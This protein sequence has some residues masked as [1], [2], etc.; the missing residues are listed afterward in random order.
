MTRQQ[1]WSSK[2]YFWT[3]TA[4]ASNANLGYSSLS[5]V[6]LLKYHLCS[7]P[8]WYLLLSNAA[9]QV[10][11]LSSP[12]FSTCWLLWFCRESVC[13]SNYDSKMN[14]CH[15]SKETTKKYPQENWTMTWPQP[16]Y[17]LYNPYQAIGGNVTLY[18]LQISRDWN[19]LYSHFVCTTK[20]NAGVQ[21]LPKTYPT[22]G[23]ETV[24][25]SAPL[26]KMLVCRLFPKI[27]PNGLE[28][29]I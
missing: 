7:F 24:T 4:V 5:K 2:A 28:T 23:L 26:R 11:C 3:S 16:H 8:L 13:Q 12:N 10:G 1:T 9:R 25:T 29:S 6:T 17:L 20:E 14:R 21:T 22:Y 18:T 19:T 15:A 27:S